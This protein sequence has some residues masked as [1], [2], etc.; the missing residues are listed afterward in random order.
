MKDNQ[1]Q[2]R[3]LISI[4]IDHASGTDRTV[5]AFKL[6]DEVQTLH[7]PIAEDVFAMLSEQIPRRQFSLPTPS[8][9]LDGE[10]KYSVKE[11]Y[12]RFPDVIE[13]MEEDDRGKILKD[14]S[15][16]RYGFLEGVRYAFDSMEEAKAALSAIPAPKGVDE[17]PD[18]TPDPVGDAFADGYAQG[19]RACALNKPPQSALPPEEE[20]MAL[21]ERYC[22]GNSPNEHD[23]KMCRDLA[24][25]I[26]SLLRQRK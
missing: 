25:S 8:S 18:E 12:R 9:R 13:P 23:H 19:Y 14:L 26:L 15:P 16:V 10:G 5:V 22:V 4:A 1:Q 2:E 3:E 11:A 24:R 20:L 6:G 7:G 21:I 17:I